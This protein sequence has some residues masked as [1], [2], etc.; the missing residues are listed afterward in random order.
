MRDMSV[1]CDV[2]SLRVTTPCVTLITPSFNQGRFIGQAIESVLEQLT[3]EVEYLVVDGGSTDGTLDILHS[4]GD[5]LCWISEPDGGQSDA[6]AKGFGRTRG[7]ILGWVNSDDK[8]APG[9]LDKIIDTFTR[10]PRAGLVY[11]DGVL[12]DEAGIESGR[13]GS[14]PFDLWRLVNVADYILQ[15]SAYFRRTAYEAAGGLDRNLRY[16]M[17]WDLWIRLARVAE[18]VYLPEVLACSRVWHGTKTFTGGWHRI[19]EISDVAL[20]HTGRRFTPAVRQYALQTAGAALRCW[21]PGFLHPAA[22][23]IKQSVSRKLDES[24]RPDRP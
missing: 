17:D 20:R 7:E 2:A 13:A 18:V 1:T 21:L 23:A 24:S 8:L 3:P 11:G 12:I 10:H 19:A 16:A 4:Y 6:L 22:A 5:R 15:P 9:A 14:E